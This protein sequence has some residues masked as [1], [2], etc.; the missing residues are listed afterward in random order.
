[1]VNL[2]IEQKTLGQEK[3]FPKFEELEAEAT[4]EL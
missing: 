4:Q 1:L 2:E 3:L